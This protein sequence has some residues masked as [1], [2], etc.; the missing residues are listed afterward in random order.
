MKIIYIGLLSLF[1]HIALLGQAPCNE[2]LDSFN[3]TPNLDPETEYLPFL[4]E[5]YTNAHGLIVPP[6]ED[7]S[8]YKKVITWVHGMNG[9]S[10]SWVH[11]SDYAEAH[12]N[13]LP[14]RIDYSDFQASMATVRAG[15]KDDFQ[16]KWEA[17]K[18]LTDDEGKRN[19]FAIAH[20]L[21]GIA[22]RGASESY[23]YLEGK[24][25]GI[26][27]VNSPHGGSDLADYVNTFEGPAQPELI[28]DMIEF[29]EIT[30]KAMAT[31]PVEEKI[32]NNKWLRLIKRTK[33]L[34]TSFVTQAG[35]SIGAD[36]VVPLLIKGVAPSAVSELMPGSD[37]LDVTS[38]VPDAHKMLFAT[39]IVDDPEAHHHAFK[40]FF[41]AQNSPSDRPQFGADGL[42][43]EALDS[44]MYDRNW[45]NAKYQEWKNHYDDKHSWEAD[46]MCWKT[47]LPTGILCQTWGDVKSI[48][49]GYDRGRFQFRQI[50]DF[51]EYSVGARDYKIYEPLDCSGL[52]FWQLSTCLVTNAVNGIYPIYS[53]LKDYDGLLTTE[54]QAEWESCQG[55]NKFSLTPNNGF[56]GSDHLQIKNDSNAKFIV[57]FTLTGGGA[58]FFGNE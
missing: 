30:C 33:L 6:P 15:V 5:G 44:L 17:L 19:S 22:I 12:Y 51:W 4:T 54:S 43:Q 1:A 58:D 20:S 8:E 2:T 18:D 50:N 9:N 7:G 47:A 53:E 55:I 14:L 24:I 45:Y 3:F 42:T 21:G 39:S 46:W 29:A 25:N 35:C 31:G 52:P 23:P 37:A 26:V 13:A 16:T 10:S 28:E 56:K 49:N 38:R 27:T 57:D 32:V 36:L 34:N 40:L 48:R 11:A 41:S